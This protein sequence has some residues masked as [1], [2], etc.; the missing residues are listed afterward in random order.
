MIGQK[1]F[2]VTFKGPVYYVI[3]YIWSYDDYFMR[4]RD[5]EINESGHENLQYLTNHRMNSIKY[6]FK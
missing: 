1:M 6:T 3:I 2:Y 5:F 4:S